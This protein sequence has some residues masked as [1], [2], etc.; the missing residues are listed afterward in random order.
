M[1]LNILNG[2]EHQSPEQ[3]G[4]GNLPV[5]K[6][7]IV[8]RSFTSNASNTIKIFFM[9]LRVLTRKGLLAACPLLCVLA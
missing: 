4:T 5:R 9:M 8:M 2:Y 7:S 1:N 6:H 3:P